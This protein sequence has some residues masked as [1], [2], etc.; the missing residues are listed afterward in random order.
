MRTPVL[1]I[2]FFVFAV[3]S[4]SAF[5][6]CNGRNLKA[7][8]TE[9]IRL[10]FLA[11]NAYAEGQFEKT[12]E[13][14]QREKKFPPALIL[15]AKAEYFSG[16]FEEAELSCRRALK[17][18]PSSFEARLYLARALREREDFKKKKKIIESLLAD[19]PY[20][21]RTLYLAAELAAEMG[22]NTEAAVFLD[23]AADLS[24]DSA[25]VLLNRA[26]LRWAAGKRDEALEDLSRAKNMLPW[27][28]PLMRS[29]NNLENTIREAL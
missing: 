23:R 25:M 24:G 3:L 5:G 6:A 11:S 4:V 10:Y 2:T 29:I 17:Y 21:I 22:K 18:R 26:R 20:D 7:E 15:R 27:D 12:K 28:T 9:T 13:I 1:R 16:D 14:L 19:N 8:D